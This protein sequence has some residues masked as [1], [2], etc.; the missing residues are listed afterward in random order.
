MTLRL[1]A[2]VEC[3]ECHDYFEQL[4]SIRGL[5]GDALEERVHEL[6]L[7]AEDDEWQ[8]RKNATEHLCTRCVENA[9]AF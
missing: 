5:R 7:A 1:L 3:D 2:C 6:V 9:N 8:S 4:V